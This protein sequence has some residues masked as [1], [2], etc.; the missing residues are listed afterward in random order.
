MPPLIH[1]AHPHIAT[2]GDLDDI[3]LHPLSDW[4][5]PGTHIG[6]AGWDTVEPSYPLLSD[7]VGDGTLS[8]QI[9]A[10]DGGLPDSGFWWTTIGALLS[11]IPNWAE[12]YGARL[13]QLVL[14]LDL[15]PVSDLALIPVVWR[16]GERLIMRW[17]SSTY[18]G[19]LGGTV[20]EFQFKID[21]GNPGAD[22][23]LSEA[24][25]ATL[26][27][28]LAGL[29]ATAWGAGPAAWPATV[30]FTEIGVVQKEETSA[31][32]KDGKGGNLS[33]SYGTAWYMYPSGTVVSGSSG[34]N[35]LP[36][37]VATAVTL[38]TNH[39]GPS[40]RGRLYLPPTHINSMAAG[41][42][43][44]NEFVVSCN[45][46]IAL[47][48]EAVILATP[49]VPVVVSR[50]RLILNEIVSVACGQVPD[51]QRRRR[52]SQSEAPVELVLS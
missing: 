33:Q 3:A 31:T 36:F 16:A 17:L 29:W 6:P 26:A 28:Q 35:P 38:Q 37:E 19:S 39:R 48:L 7:G 40:G 46:L 30:K 45:S 1:R 23:D 8:L 27:E 41:G 44:T 15:G 52:R 5:P 4:P 47:Y 51:S 34:A 20:E 13:A 32:D 43:Y 24:G 22:P 50:R 21:F 9:I 18:R 42:I 12:K 25:A 49:Y 2:L 14:E 10:D 11:P